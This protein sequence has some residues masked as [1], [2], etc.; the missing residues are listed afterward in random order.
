MKDYSNMGIC[1]REAEGELT[2][3]QLPELAQLVAFIEYSKWLKN[4]FASNQ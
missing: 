4:I 1:P 3:N 2:Q